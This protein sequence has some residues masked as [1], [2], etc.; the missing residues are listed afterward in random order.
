MSLLNATSTCVN[1]YYPVNTR[2]CGEVDYLNVFGDKLFA[3]YC[4]V[5][6]T[7]FRCKTK[8]SIAH[9][10]L[11]VFFKRHIR[12]DYSEDRYIYT[13]T[14]INRT[15]SEND[16]MEITYTQFSSIYDSPMKEITINKPTKII[17]IT[18]NFSEKEKYRYQY[19]V[20]LA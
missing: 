19:N 16:Y 10:Q 1:R 5:P 15:D 6:K 11:E 17:C 18:D 4:V 3:K 12:Y 14:R 2:T 20:S 13:V 9:N 7:V 8:T